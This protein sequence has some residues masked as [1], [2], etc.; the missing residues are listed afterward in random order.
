M[1]TGR[2]WLEVLR[3]HGLSKSGKQQGALTVPV[4]MRVGN[5]KHVAEAR[6]EVE[7]ARD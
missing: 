1:L 2:E 6:F 3:E 7:T 5:A 4:E